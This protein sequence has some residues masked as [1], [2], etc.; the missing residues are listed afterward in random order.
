MLIIASLYPLTNLHITIY[1]I[2]QRRHLKQVKLMY[3][4]SHKICNTIANIFP[5]C[6]L[7]DDIVALADLRTEDKDV[8]SIFDTWIKG[9]V[10]QYNIDG[11]R[12]D[13]AGNVNPSFFSKEFHLLSLPFKTQ[14]PNSDS[15][16][17]LHLLKLCWF[18]TST[19][20]NL[21]TCSYV[22]RFS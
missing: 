13:S 5:Q 1:P 12:L 16:T 8:Q 6:W 19:F 20:S 18:P 21:V 7:G 9:L 2:A 22:L 15:M 17:L 3:V 11:L 14:I 10:S 4:L